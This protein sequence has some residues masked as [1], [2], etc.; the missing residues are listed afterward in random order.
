MASLIFGI[1]STGLFGYGTYYCF[2]NA[3]KEIKKVNALKTEMEKSVVNFSDRSCLITQ[4]I[5]FL[6]LTKPQYYYS[7]SKLTFGKGIE[8]RQYNNHNLFT[9]KTTRVIVPVEVE[10]TIK[11]YV[12][13]FLSDPTFDKLCQPSKSVQYMF[14]THPSIVNCD[15]SYLS[16][17]L[18]EKHGIR[19]M[20]GENRDIFELQTTVMNSHV[21]LLGENVGEQFIY[22]AI[23]DNKENLINKVVSENDSSDDYIIGGILCLG[24]LV[25][26]LVATT[27]ELAKQK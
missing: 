9:D 1:W 10:S 16:H 6:P 7:I 13:T 22:R 12:N 17:L 14:Y 21:F 27:T 2:N 24:S 3:S 20:Y 11:T 18:Q 26:S 5:V 19:L 4:G 8:L 25:L 23:S 15:G